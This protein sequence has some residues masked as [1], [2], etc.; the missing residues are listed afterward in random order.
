MRTVV[1]RGN[2]MHC[3][4]VI[5]TISHLSH[6]C[7]RPLPELIAFDVIKCI[8]ADSTG[9]TGACAPVLIKEPGQRSPFAPVI[10]RESIMV[11]ILSRLDTHDYVDYYC[12]PTRLFG[13]S[14]TPSV[15]LSVSKCSRRNPWTLVGVVQYNSIPSAGRTR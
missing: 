14:V 10:F 13:L 6:L 8:G 7:I 9:A 4:F 11:S 12:A 5:I 15:R 2:L 1:C 3:F